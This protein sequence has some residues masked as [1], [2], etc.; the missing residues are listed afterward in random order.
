MQKRT[1]TLTVNIPS[2]SDFCAA[3]PQYKNVVKGGWGK[4]L[5]GIIMRPESYVKTVCATV[6]L[7]LPGVAGVAEDCA[8][9]LTP[10][11]KGVRNQFCGAVVCCLMEANSFQKTGTKKAVPHKA[12]SKGEVYAK[13]GNWTGLDWK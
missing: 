9:V 8:H 6:D 4:E 11:G 2:T 13:P 1:I 12:F 7:H 3:Y 5:F 10:V